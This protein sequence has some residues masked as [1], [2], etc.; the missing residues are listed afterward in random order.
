MY[1]QARRVPV[2]L[3]AT[4]RLQ[5]WFLE[6]GSQWKGQ[7]FSKDCFW[8][9][10]VGWQVCT[11]LEH[12]NYTAVS[13]DPGSMWQ[14]TFLRSSNQVPLVSCLSSLPMAAF[15]FTLAGQEL[16]SKT[17]K[18]LGENAAGERKKSA[19]GLLCDFW[20][21]LGATSYLLTQRMRATR[22]PYRI[23]LL[24]RGVMD[25]SRNVST[26]SCLPAWFFY[27]GVWMTRKRYR[28]NTFS[29]GIMGG[30]CSPLF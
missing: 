13:L 27:L 28:N 5:V 17:L 11:C 26:I 29:P 19:F 14:L 20:I 1:E 18:T 8:M 4:Y 24:A 30:S 6:A 2:W 23:W 9:T 21:L 10:W 16:C 7:W 25:P 15:G 3:L 12:R 22:S